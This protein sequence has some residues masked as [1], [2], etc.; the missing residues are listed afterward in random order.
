[1]TY[2]ANPYTQNSSS[3]FV[4]PEQRDRATDFLQQAF[5]DGRITHDEFDQR[6]GIVLAAKTRADL[7]PALDGLAIV[8]PGEPPIYRGPNRYEGTVHYTGPVRYGGSNVYRTPDQIKESTAGASMAYWFGFLFWIFGP[9]LL[10]LLASHGSFT[11]RAAARAFNM[12][13]KLTGLI[14]ASGILAGITFGVTGVLC[15]LIS[16]FALILLIVGGVKT[17]SGELW[18]DP[19]LSLPGNV[20]PE[21]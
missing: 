16:I 17:A 20:L 14:I 7:M 4:T 6:L 15:G 21:D 8:P 18:D 10:Y 11:K 2:Y 12:M 3:F 1:M 5:A 9:G 13:L 19:L